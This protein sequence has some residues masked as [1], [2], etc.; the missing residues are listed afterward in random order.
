MEKMKSALEIALE[1]AKKLGGRD[2]KDTTGLKNRK[3]IQAALSLGNS[4]LQGKTGAEKIKESLGRYPA[5]SQEEAR[6]TF[7]KAITAEMNLANTPQ[8]LKAVRL[9]KEE[10]GVQAACT[11]VKKYHQQLLQQ[12]KEKKAALQ[13][14]SFEPLLE[15]MGLTGLRGSALAGFNTQHLPGWEE[16]KTQLLTGYEEQLHNFRKNIFKQ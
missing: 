12:L 2:K 4:F 8:I 11:E 16:T 10:T 3:Y 14:S 15:K 9:L 5:E 13:E 1:K 7:L 6:E